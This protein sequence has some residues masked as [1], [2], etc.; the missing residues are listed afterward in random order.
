[1]VPQNGW[2]LVPNKELQWF[3]QKIKKTFRIIGDANVCTNALRRT[4]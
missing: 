2:T 3:Q 1:M 4:I